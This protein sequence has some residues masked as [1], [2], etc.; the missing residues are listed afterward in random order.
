[1]TLILS[2]E[3]IA[4]LLPISDC[5]DRMEDAYRELGHDRAINRPRSDICAPPQEGGQYIFKS[6]DGLLPKYEVAALR[7]ESRMSSKLEC[8]IIL[9]TARQKEPMGPGGTWIGLVMLSLD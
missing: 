2:N 8:V 9:G 1:M 7:L 3:E 5:L 4:E 6:M